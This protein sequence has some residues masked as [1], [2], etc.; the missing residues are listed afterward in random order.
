MN[1]EEFENYI[2]ETYGIKKDCPWMKYPEY[3]VFRHASNQKWFAL[4]MD[5]PKDRLSLQEDGFLSVVNFKCDPTFITSLLCEPGFYP[6]YH[7]NKEKWITVALDGSVSGDK[8]KLLLDMSY[9]MT[10]SKMQKKKI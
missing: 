7:M 8:I 9:E 3:A 5:L 2:T 10:E 6:A 4:V 1:R